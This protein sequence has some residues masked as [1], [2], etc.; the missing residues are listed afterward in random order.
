MLEHGQKQ[1]V[2]NDQ[3]S[4]I[5]CCDVG[6]CNYACCEDKWKSIRNQSWKVRM[7]S[8]FLKYY[9][10][11]VCTYFVFTIRTFTIFAFLNLYC[12]I[13]LLDIVNQKY[14]AI[15]ENKWFRKRSIWKRNLM[16]QKFCNV[17]RGFKFFVINR[18]SFEIIRLIS[19]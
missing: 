18:I 10:N 5:C 1:P 19:L 6:V 3:Q 8:R 14:F 13:L 4:R 12:H 17:W 15:N 2:L 9:Y 11:N 16:I 7:N